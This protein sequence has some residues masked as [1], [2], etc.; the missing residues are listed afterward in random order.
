VITAVLFF[1]NYGVGKDMSTKEVVDK[2]EEVEKNITT[3]SKVWR[4]G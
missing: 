1:P 3:P 4:I 2:L